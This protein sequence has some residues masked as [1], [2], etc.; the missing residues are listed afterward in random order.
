MRS[1]TRT[2]ATLPSHLGA[3]S[4]VAGLAMAAVSAAAAYGITAT[5][6]DL[7]PQHD[8]EY[9]A[10]GGV[11]FAFGDGSVRS[12][13]DSISSNLYRALAT[14][15]AAKSS[16]TDM[17]RRH[18]SRRVGVGPSGGANPSRRWRGCSP[19]TCVP[20]LGLPPASKTS[21]DR[22]TVE[23]FHLHPVHGASSR[24]RTTR[25]NDVATPTRAHAERHVDLASRAACW[26]N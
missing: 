7:A 8:P 13:R 23:S 9:E 21:C 20:R 10:G 16:L 18:G 26:I 2:A 1:T 24:T 19:L 17:F 5:G 15:S 14:T 6:L 3:R 22:P 25:Q 12:V 4:I 11:N